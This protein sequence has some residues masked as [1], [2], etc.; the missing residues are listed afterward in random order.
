[1]NV[2]K[3]HSILYDFRFVEFIIAQYDMK[4]SIIIVVVVVCKVFSHITK[5]NNC[6]EALNE[7]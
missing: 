5:Y 6:Y 4:F 2:H 1:M 7:L 3:A